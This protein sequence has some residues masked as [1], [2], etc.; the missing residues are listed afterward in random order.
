MDTGK[1][2]EIVLTHV[3]CGTE[4]GFSCNVK[5]SPPECDCST[6]DAEQVLHMG[7]GFRQG[8]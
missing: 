4:Y 6:G 3:L 1:M 2:I 5:A 7:F 8:P